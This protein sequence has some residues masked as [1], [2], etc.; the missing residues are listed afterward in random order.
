MLELVLSFLWTISL[1]ASLVACTVAAVV[2]FATR[3]LH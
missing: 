2:V 1:G 3:K